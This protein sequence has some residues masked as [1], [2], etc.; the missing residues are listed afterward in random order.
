[1]AI[2]DDIW[3][4]LKDSVVIGK[5]SNFAILLTRAKHKKTPYMIKT[6][7]DLFLKMW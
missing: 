4:L 7:K 1:M 3:D 5:V 6:E 2:M